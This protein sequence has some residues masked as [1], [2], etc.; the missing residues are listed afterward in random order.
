MGRKNLLIAAAL[1]AALYLV[2]SRGLDRTREQRLERASQN[3]GELK[4]SSLLPTYIGSLFLGSFRAVAIDILWIQMSRMRQQEHRYFE[5]VEIMDLITKL[6]PRN[7][8]AWAYQANDAAYQI[9]N[10]FRTEPDQRE[11]RALEQEIENHAL[12]PEREAAVRARIKMLKARIVENR[13]QYTKWV[14]LGLET[15]LEGARHLPEDPYLKYMI[16][17]TLLYKAAI[18]RG[19]FETEFLEFI[20]KDEELQAELSGQAGPGE[21]RSAFMLAELWMART[22]ENLQMLAREGRF[23]FYRDLAEHL[24]RKHEDQ[25]RTHHTTQVGSNIDLVTAEG[26]RFQ[27]LYLE[28]IRLWR[29]ARESEDRGEFGRVRDLLGMAAATLRKASDLSASIRKNYFA[30][31]I[32]DDRARFCRQLAAAAEEQRAMDAPL[33]PENRAKVLSRLV[34]VRAELIRTDVPTLDDDYMVEY[35]GG[36]KRSLGGDA[37][38]YNDDLH[39]AWSLYKDGPTTGAIGPDLADEDWFDVYVPFPQVDDGHGHEPREG[40]QV[41]RTTRLQLARTGDLPLIVKSF[42]FRGR[43]LKEVGSFKVENDQIHEFQIEAER[44]GLVFIRVAAASPN[45][46]GSSRRGYWIKSLGVQP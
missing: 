8:E 45:S 14:K 32:F 41:T 6:Q 44:E 37:Q 36:L 19:S 39:A 16:A 33:R 12:S 23:R 3:L 18:S 1:L 11:V 4:A 9:A 26:G 34:E 28:A 25:N 46:G 13:P 43:D 40:P 7:P 29:R 22:L 21:P 30:S 10:Q 24:R 17:Y 42:A 27:C 20:E 38:E 35:M 2:Q 15:L 31:E 5:T